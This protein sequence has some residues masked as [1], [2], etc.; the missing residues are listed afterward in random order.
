MML[1]NDILNLNLNKYEYFINHMTF[2][3]NESY[4][5]I[6]PI[7]T[8]ISFKKE[9]DIN[10][11]DYSLHNFELLLKMNDTYSNIDDNVNDF[12][13]LKY[14]EPLQITTELFPN[15]EYIK[16]WNLNRFFSLDT[17]KIDNR[18]EQY[19]D[20]YQKINLFDDEKKKIA[21]RKLTNDVNNFILKKY[22][23]TD[24][25][26]TLHGRFLDDYEYNIKYQFSEL[27]KL[28]L[29]GNI[30]RN[31]GSLVEY[32]KDQ[33]IR[34]LYKR[35][36][37]KISFD[38]VINKNNIK[39]NMKLDRKNKRRNTESNKTY[40]FTFLNLYDND[41]DPFKIVVIGCAFDND[42]LDE[43]LL[44]DYIETVNNQ[45]L[46][47]DHYKFNDLSFDLT[48]RLKINNVIDFVVLD[49]NISIIDYEFNFDN[50]DFVINNQWDIKLI[51]YNGDD[52]DDNFYYKR[53]LVPY[54]QIVKEK[55]SPND[56][57]NIFNRN[58]TY[59]SR[60]DNHKDRRICRIL[61]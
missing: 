30:V 7:Y 55:V 17:F 51:D 39:L 61:K 11:Y 47:L 36:K 59:K 49:Y 6:S 29:D 50:K 40:L 43:S 32:N 28:N 38:F 13:Y 31:N 25:D 20:Q 23:F 5:N 26:I 60:F 35:I 48:N 45:Y 8:P 57:T 1:D 58:L 21:F 24:D 44:I 52:L 10:L 14:Q 42:I 46:T 54:E 37:Q 3:N 9:I 2:N 41:G 22:N 53:I 12:P 19:N 4:V 33:I 16:E 34:Q 15:I 56:K 27:N 18:I